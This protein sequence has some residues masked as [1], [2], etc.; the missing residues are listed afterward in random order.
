MGHI[1]LILEGWKQSPKTASSTEHQ[2]VVELEGQ[3]H[4]L[5]QKGVKTI[6]IQVCSIPY[7]EVMSIKLRKLLCNY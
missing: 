2:G 6:Q 3:L 4:G 5:G 1:L 7:T